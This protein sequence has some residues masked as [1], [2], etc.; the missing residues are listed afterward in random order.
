MSDWYILNLSLT[1]SR[2]VSEQAQPA[3]FSQAVTGFS[4]AG[5]GFISFP[6]VFCGSWL[7]LIG[8]YCTVQQI[9]RKTTKMLKP[10]KITKNNQQI[11][12]TTLR[13]TK[14][15]QK[16][17]SGDLEL[18]GWPGLAG[19]PTGRLAPPAPPPP[20]P[21]SLARRDWFYLF[22]FSLLWLLIGF[23]WFLLYSTANS[24]KIN[25]NAETFQNN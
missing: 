14:K 22:S 19:W 21:S 15:P 7:V 12:K 11:T 4:H 8:F 24:K 18:A 25:K 10:S 16:T 5:I 13:T 6:L 1:C 3:R 17:R 23:D 9:Q 20:H 2:V